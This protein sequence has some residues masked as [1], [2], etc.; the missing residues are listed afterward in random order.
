MA[1]CTPTKTFQD[2]ETCRFHTVSR[3]IVNVVFDPLLPMTTEELTL[4]EECMPLRTPI[5]PETLASY[6]EKRCSRNGYI[7]IMLFYYFF[8]LAQRTG[9]PTLEGTVI[10][11]FLALEPLVPNVHGINEEVFAHLKD[12][13][14]PNWFGFHIQL[15]DT[16]L[17]PEIQERAIRPILR[18]SGYLELGL[19]D[20]R[21]NGKR[22]R[23]KHMVLIVGEDER[24]IHIKNSSRGKLLD[25]IPFQQKIIFGEIGEKK[26]CF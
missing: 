12:T 3:M 9:V 13:F 14:S 25:I 22:G 23:R 19:E 6:S 2:D 15:D 20:D 18:L 10:Q 16:D 11:K 24:G 26:R 1:A 5:R 17:F 4:Y 21:P 7:K 8:E